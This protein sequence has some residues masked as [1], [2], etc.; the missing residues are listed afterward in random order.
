MTGGTGSGQAR[1][2]LELSRTPDRIVTVRVF[3]G[4]VAREFGCSEEDA[5]DARVAASEA[6]T[7]AMVGSDAPSGSL[8]VTAD[9]TDHEVRF[10]ISHRPE[11]RGTGRPARSAD[12]PLRPSDAIP[13]GLDVIRALFA[14]AHTQ[15]D[16]T[17]AT[18]ITF[19][20]PVGPKGHS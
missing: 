19:G 3:V 18:S 9:K 16:A 8:S 5:E 4:S 15:E 1:F 2:T 20:V 11:G 10:T 14:D 6:C 12:G 13:G 7:L 17:G